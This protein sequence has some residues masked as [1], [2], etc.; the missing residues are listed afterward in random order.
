MSWPPD[1]SSMHGIWSTSYGAIYAIPGYFSITH[2]T[3]QLENLIFM[4]I[5]S[6]CFF[7]YIFL[8]ELHTA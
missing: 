5:L 4:Q 2:D 6:L 1:R 3:F 8:Y 7:Y